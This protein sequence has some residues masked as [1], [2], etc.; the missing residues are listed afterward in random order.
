M[1]TQDSA[2]GSIVGAPI[3]TLERY[4][5]ANGWSSERSGDEEIVAT[6]DGTWGK[7]EVRA[8]WREEDNVL[9]IVG[10]PGLKIPADH[11]T[12]GYELAGRI[13][14]QLWLGHF[15]IWSGDGSILFRHAALLMEPE[16]EAD[17]P[18]LSL[19]QAGTFVEAAI[20]ECDR[21]Y[22]AFDFLIGGAHSPT[23]ALAAALIDVA[24]EA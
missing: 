18:G 21:Y 10:M 12:P 9:Q 23:E 4:F 6:V 13:N 7:I 19:D 17:G 22:P 1:M 16:D 2:V 24:G 15:D 3:E 11:R 14:E 20:D 5:G 8:L